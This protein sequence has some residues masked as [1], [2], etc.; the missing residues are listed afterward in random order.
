M[1]GILSLSLES[2]NCFSRFGPLFFGQVAWIVLC[3][4]RRITLRPSQTHPLVRASRLYTKTKFSFTKKIQIKLT[5]KILSM[6]S[7]LIISS[8]MQGFMRSF[9]NW[10]QFSGSLFFLVFLPIEESVTNLQDSLNNFLAD[11]LKV[12]SFAQGWLFS[13]SVTSVLGSVLSTTDLGVE[14]VKSNGVGGNFTGFSVCNVLPTTYWLRTRTKIT[15]LENADTHIS[16]FMIL[17]LKGKKVLVTN[18]GL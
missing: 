3:N 12:L 1:R 2:F 18:M 16:S 14:D 13:V 4:S 5:F 9:V 6:H 11:F 17:L 10:R 15:C 8:S 7:S